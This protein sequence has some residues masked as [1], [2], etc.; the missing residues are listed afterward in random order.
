MLIYYNQIT[1]ID[2]KNGSIKIYADLCG[3]MQDQKWL[4]LHR[5]VQIYAD[6]A[7]FDPT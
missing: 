5:S 1:D 4:D 7:N 3:S 2:P 6:Q